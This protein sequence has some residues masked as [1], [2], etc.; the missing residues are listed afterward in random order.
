M[1]NIPRS[2]ILDGSLNI[3]VYGVLMYL[4]SP[5]SLEVGLS[6]GNLG[7]YHHTQSPHDSDDVVF[8]HLVMMRGK[9]YTVKP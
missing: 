7:V 3:G 6:A 9:L 4:E 1:E 2:K 5:T 8:T